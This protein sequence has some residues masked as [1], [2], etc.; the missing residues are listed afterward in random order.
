MGLKNKSG[1]YSN[2]KILELIKISLKHLDYNFLNHYIRCTH[3]QNGGEK[4][5]NLFNDLIPLSIIEN[6]KYDLKLQ[7]S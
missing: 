3:S 2:L 5:V 4:A 6:S 7:N 1:N